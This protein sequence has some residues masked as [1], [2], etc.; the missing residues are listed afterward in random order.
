MG[1][2]P[3]Y[4]YTVKIIAV[5][6]FKAH[7]PQKCN[8]LCNSHHTTAAIPSVTAEAIAAAIMPDSQATTTEYTACKSVGPTTVAISAANTGTT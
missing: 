5:N 8:C 2:T 7:A 6:S 1:N 3:A 4:Y